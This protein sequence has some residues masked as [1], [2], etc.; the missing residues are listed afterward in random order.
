M[1]DFSYLA[2]NYDPAQVEEAIAD[3]ERELEDEIA[4]A[5]TLGKD[6]AEKIQFAETFV[7]DNSS[8]IAAQQ[9]RLLKLHEELHKMVKQNQERQAADA[10]YDAL[11]NTPSYLDVA[12]MMLNIKSVVTGLRDFL[13]KEGVRGRP[14]M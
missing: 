3:L 12:D 8:L 2:H 5:D 10:Q 7:Q 14:P 11:V 13:V 4:L 9:E 1:S 6:S